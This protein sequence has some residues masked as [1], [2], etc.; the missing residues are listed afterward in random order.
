M[1][2]DEKK[3]KLLI[4][5]SYDGILFL[6]KNLKII[7]ASPSV[8]PLLGY[9]PEQLV[10]Q[11]H[12]YLTHSDD[13][14]D[15][16]S[17]FRDLLNNEKQNISI[18][19][20]LLHHK[21]YYIWTEAS[22]TNLLQEEGIHAIISHF[23]DITERINAENRLKK[24]NETLEN[25]VTERTYA[26]EEEIEQR[27][28]LT[29]ELQVAKDD[30]DRSNQAKAEFLANMSHEIRSPLNAI[31]G[32]TQLMLLQSK[33]TPI[34]DNFRYYLENIKISGENLSDLINN[35]LDL[36]KIEA[37]KM[38]LV[39]EVLSLRQLFQGIFHINKSDAAERGIKFSY[40][41]DSQVPNT[42]ETDRT[43]LNQILMN[44]VSNALKFTPKG[45]NVYLRAYQ[46]KELTIFEVR[47]EGVGIPPHR[48]EAIFRPFEQA[49]NSITRKFGGT[50]LGLTITKRMVEMLNGT[51]E[52]KSQEGQGST[53]IVKIP[54]KIVETHHNTKNDFA[55][56]KAHFSKQNKILLFEDNLLNQQ[57]IMD[58]L[59]HFDLK[60]E[61]AENG[62]IGIEKAKQLLPNLIMMDLHM[63][64]TDGLQA[65]QYLRSLPEFAQTPIVAI[66]ADAFIEQQ[67][68][69]FA[70]GVN[71]YLTK[72]ID[73]RKL[74]E[75]LLECLIIE[76]INEDTTNTSLETLSDNAQQVLE[77]YLKKLL[78]TPIYQTEDLE[79]DLHQIRYSLKKYSI[80][81]EEKFARVEDAI[82]EGDEIQIHL[83]AQEIAHKYLHQNQTN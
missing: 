38:E 75:I 37:G 23:R 33:D 35:I 79:N 74:F 73:L 57:I 6:D 3:F 29:I 27:K 50:G 17:T 69:A 26:L 54:L 44:L 61:V 31:V 58:F 62:D 45:K 71:Y 40:Y 25:K 77:Q 24:L 28:E 21:N 76:K 16:A 20:R 2:I 13:A 64:E 42:V 18:K 83:L 65:T 55:F 67:E 36:S 68:K 52:V 63:P 78:K 51:I 70:K 47:D 1:Q 66:S 56:D 12:Y 30:A 22:L 41:F 60:L 46:Q 14:H 19:Q 81:L 53:F 15:N 10:G 82:F 11:Y 49:D 5:H 59:H 43:K 4:E 32:F 48:L 9:Q 34:D 39:N 72:P 8:F 80:G 7:Y